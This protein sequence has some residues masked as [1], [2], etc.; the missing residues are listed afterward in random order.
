MSEKHKAEEMSFEE[1]MKLL[2]DTVKKLEKGDATLE[3]SMALFTEGMRLSKICSDRIAG[4][5]SRISMLVSDSG[6]SAESGF[7]VS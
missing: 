1:A 5:E 2:E 7:E 4:I 6:E 3:E